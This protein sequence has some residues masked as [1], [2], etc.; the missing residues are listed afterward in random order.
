ML[1]RA[2]S[3]A[4]VRSLPQCRRT[5]PS[6]ALVPVPRAALAGRAEPGRG[7]RVLRPAEAMGRVA[8]HALCVWADPTSRRGPHALCDWAEHEFGPVHPVKFY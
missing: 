2:A 6:C 4:P 3:R 1:Y 5:A 7:P 8:A